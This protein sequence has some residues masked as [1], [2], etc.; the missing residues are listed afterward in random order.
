VARAV[1]SLDVG[2]HDGA[3]KP[4]VVPRGSDHMG[5]PHLS[6]AAVARMLGI[7]PA[8]LR[9]WDRRYGIGPSAHAPGRHR[10]Y[11]PDDIARLEM[12]RH[13]LVRGVGPA[14]AAR[15]ALA[16]ERHPAPS[17]EGARPR[18]G[19]TML[20]LP[21]AGHYARGLGRA[22]LALDF[23]AARAVL[24][25]AVAALGIVATWDDVVRPVLAAVAQRWATTGAGVEV[26]HLLSQSVAAVFSA[27]DVSRDD[28]PE[29]RSVLL[30][31][32]PGEQ[33][34]LPLVVLAAALGD[35]SVPVRPMGTDLPGPA[36]VAA[37]RR[38]APAGVVLWSQVS[39]TAD[40]TLLDMVPETRPRARTF[41]AGPGWDEAKLPGRVR[42]LTSL[43]EA[44]E[45]L[46]AAT[47]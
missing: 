29:G 23:R 41:V 44:I 42:R 24:V 16:A 43:V 12:M 40:V 28:E 35:R 45:A 8:T 15:Y 32:M 22:A 36:L 17:A 7:A 20:R 1:A 18:A 27:Y 9:T 31:G 46:V 5:E 30:T 19:G 33:H 38:T 6:V 14:E 4:E 34:V 13:A 11:S 3:V 10:R 37:V 39:E 2:A 26:E 25:E 47:R 21:G